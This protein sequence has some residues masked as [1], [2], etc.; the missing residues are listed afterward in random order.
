MTIAPPPEYVVV[1]YEYLEQ[2]YKPDK[3]R[4]ALF[5]TF[6]RIL[7]LAWQ[8]KYTQT[9]RMKED[10]LIEFLKLSRR[11]YFEQKADMELLGWL[12]SSH[13]VTGFVQFT[14][15]RAA[16]SVDPNAVSAENR[17]EVQKS[18]P[19]LGGG[20]SLN[21]I[22]NTD[23]IPPHKEEVSA[24]NRTFPGIKEILRHTDKLFDGAVVYSQGL[25]DRDPLQ[26][27]GWCAYV[28]SLK[29]K[30]DGPGGVVRN[31][32]K[33]NEPAPQ[34]AIGQWRDVLPCDFLE[35]LALIEY[36][37]E[38]CQAKFKK[39]ADLTAHEATHPKWYVCGACGQGFTNHEDLDAHTDQEHTPEL[40]QPD[41][42]VSKPIRKGGSMTPAQAWQ[43][44]LGQLEQE[45]PR[46]AFDNWVRTTRAIRYGRNTLSIE[47]RNAYARDWLESRLSSTVNRLL[48]GIMNDGSIAVEFVVAD[49][50]SA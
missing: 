37:C 44:V 14:F 32:L 20:E 10:E 50:V 15:S 36:T 11:Q 46:A 48:V 29:S 8:S 4:R 1:P 45:M 19:V 23:S 31:R 5:A 42:S 16:V 39:L 18:A 2:A 9:P 47:A 40:I 6:V 35:A 26:V 7:A 34:S 22:L 33:D 12:R 13:P 30:F 41:E 27:L 28:Y 24:E 38:T 3:P 17:T 43:S 49:E 21:L 25:E